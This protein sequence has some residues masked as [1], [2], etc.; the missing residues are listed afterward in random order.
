MAAAMRCGE[1]PRQLPRLVQHVPRLSEHLPQL[2]IAE[3]FAAAAAAAAS[4]AAEPF[5]APGSALQ[6][7]RRPH[8]EGHEQVQARGKMQQ[9]ED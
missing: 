9:R 7:P 1:R 5:A 3:P 6:G 2:A 4:V 8:E